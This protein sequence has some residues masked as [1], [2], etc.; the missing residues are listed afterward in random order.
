M[1]KNLCLAL[2]ATGL[3]WGGLPARAQETVNPDLF[4]NLKWREIGPW[5]GGRVTAVTGVPGNDRLYYMGAT[6]GGRWKTENAGISWGVPGHPQQEA[7]L[8]PQRTGALGRAHR[9]GPPKRGSHHP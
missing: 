1:H 2:V 3:L 9:A 8:R 4:G 7:P 6:G 5:R